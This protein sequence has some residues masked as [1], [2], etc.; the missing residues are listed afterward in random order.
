[1]TAPLN[2][3]LGSLEEYRK[4]LISTSA[5]DLADIKNAATSR[6]RL[7]R[8]ANS[9]HVNTVYELR[10]VSVVLGVPAGGQGG[11]KGAPTSILDQ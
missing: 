5:T 1:M 11:S 10:F 9:A 2:I 6:V 8:S 3:W 4:P 7:P